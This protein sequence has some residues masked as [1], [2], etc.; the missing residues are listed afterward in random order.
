MTVR[1]AAHGRWRSIL[2]ALGIDAIHLTGK[3]GPCPLCKGGK[4]RWRFDDKDGAGTFYCSQCGAG[5]GVKLVMMALGLDFRAA[6]IRIEELAGAAPFQPSKPQRTDEQRRDA[7]NGLWRRSRPIQP[8]DPAAHYLATRCFVAS[9]PADL[10]HVAEARYYH[11]K[12]RFTSHPAMLAM[13]R[14]LSGKPVNVHRTFLTPDGRKAPY[15]DARKLMEGTLP[16]GAAIRLCAHADRL[17]AAE[18]IETALSAT[19]LFGDPCWALVSADNLSAWTPPEGV[20]VAPIFADHDRSYAGQAAAYTLAKR[21]IAKNIEA[22]VH[23]PEQLGDDWN[24]V[25]RRKSADLHYRE[26]ERVA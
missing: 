18:G 10:R 26:M 16:K 23:L 9:Y 8:G 25:H 6:A 20:T 14:D 13:V 22:P 2:P 24:D 15:D 4:D 21:L 7:M 12:T 5:D 1:E 17:G 3:H 19:A 11:D